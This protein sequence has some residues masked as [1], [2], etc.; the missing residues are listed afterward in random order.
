MLEQ[1]QTRKT[2]SLRI[3]GRKNLEV[4]ETLILRGDRSL[5]FQVLSATLVE[6]S[7][8]A[9]QH[10]MLAWAFQQSPAILEDSSLSHTAARNILVLG[11][12]GFVTFNTS[13]SNLLTF[14]A[15]S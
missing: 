14:A 15:E 1:T 6:L 8:D 5:E 10:M 4:Q 7:I 13:T 2:V 9:K 3:H 12:R 11:R